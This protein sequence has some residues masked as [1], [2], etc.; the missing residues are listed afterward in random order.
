MD[1]TLL[2]DR[3][4]SKA[5]P[6][7]LGIHWNQLEIVC[8]VLDAKAWDSRVCFLPP[9]WLGIGSL[10]C[11]IGSWRE[12]VKVVSVQAR[13]SVSHPSLSAF[14]AH[15]H[16]NPALASGSQSDP[17]SQVSSYPHHTHTQIPSI[18]I[19]LYIYMCVC[20][21][22]IYIYMYIWYNQDRCNRIAHHHPS[23]MMWRR[24]T[25]SPCSSLDKRR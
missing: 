3:N 10:I 12:V 14:G 1:E 19:Y 20:V 25:E 15:H 11:R 5:L 23:R 22:E 7:R 16:T 18:V 24:A 21:Y 6:N 4:R 9:S 13:S 2:R 17:E 8:V